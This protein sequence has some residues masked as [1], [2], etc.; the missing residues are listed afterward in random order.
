MTSPSC[1]VSVMLYLITARIAVC[2]CSRRN[3]INRLAAFWRSFKN[4]RGN[5][6]NCWVSPRLQIRFQL[7]DSNLE[8]FITNG[9]RF[10]AQLEQER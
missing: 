7:T 4:Y 2:L 9:E 8:I 1:S 5:E 10:L 6:L 3:G